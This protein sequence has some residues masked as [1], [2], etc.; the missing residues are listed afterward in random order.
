A[1]RFGWNEL[2]RQGESLES[3]RKKVEQVT[4]E[5]I[6]QVCRECFVSSGLNIVVVG[7]YAQE[8]EMQVNALASEFSP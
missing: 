5:Q 4:R 6:L 1:D 3:E 2:Y 7:Q 8:E